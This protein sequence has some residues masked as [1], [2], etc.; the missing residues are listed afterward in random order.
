MASGSGK[1]PCAGEEI[2]Q[3]RLVACLRVAMLR[4]LMATPREQLTRLAGYVPFHALVALLEQPE[5]EFPPLERRDGAILR[6]ELSGISALAEALASR[7]RAGAEELARIESALLGGLLENALFP[8]DGYLLRFGGESLTA[9]FEGREA[10]LRAGWCA[11]TML[12]G[13]AAYGAVQ[14]AAGVRTIKA[15]AGIATGPFS[16]VYLG[17]GHDRVAC[18]PGGATVKRAVEGAQGA[19]WG[20]AVA[21]EATF[22]FAKGLQKGKLTQGGLL[23]VERAPEI[24]RTPVRHLDAQIAAAPAAALERLLPLVPEALAPT[25]EGGRAELQ[26]ELKRATV[27]LCRFG[28]ADW[29][30]AR[31]TADARAMGE[32][33]R[34]AVL[35]VRR[36]GGRVGPVDFALDGFRMLATFSSPGVRTDAE[37]AAAC[38]IELKGLGLGVAMEGGPTF[39]AEVGSGLKR[40]LAVAGDAADLAGRLL[41]LARLGDA[42][43]GPAVRGQLWGFGIEALPQVVFEEKGSPA[44]PGLLLAAPE[45]QPLRARPRTSEAKSLGGPI[46]RERELAVL[47]DR[48]QR[49]RSGGSALVLLHGESG[50]GKSV[51]LDALGADW[52]TSG[53]SAV[54]AR[55]TFADSERPWALAGRL[56]R[57]LLRLP[58]D[59]DPGKAPDAV[60]RL[61]RRLS[62][63]APYAAVLLGGRGPATPE[64]VAE[65]LRGIL[66]HRASEAPLLV[67][68][69][70]AHYADASSAAIW[71]ELA[72][73]LADRPIF[74]VAAHCREAL[75]DFEGINTERLE[76]D[77]LDPT[78]AVQV[79]AQLEPSLEPE[80]LQRAAEVGRGNPFRMQCAAQILRKKGKVADDADLLGAWTLGLEE[81]PQT[82]AELVAVFGGARASVE[83]LHEALREF[84][85]HA[86]GRDAIA[87]LEKRELLERRLGKLRFRARAVQEAIYERLNPERRSL[88]HGAIGRA[89]KLCEPESA[90]AIF[91]FHFARSDSRFE[92]VR[93]CIRAGEDA[94]LAGAWPE[95]A[96]FFGKA[97]RAAEASRAPELA[98]AL[99]R[100]A[101]ALVRQGRY[102]EVRALAE[103]AAEA[104]RKS[105]RT[106]ALSEA[107]SALAQAAL[108]QDDIE[109]AKVAATEA[110]EVVVWAKDAELA[111]ELFAMA[112]TVDAVAGD[113]RGA[114]KYARQAL[115]SAKRQGSPVLLARA[116]AALGA[117]AQVGGHLGGAAR[118][119]AEA[120][121][122]F[123]IAGDPGRAAR[124]GAQRALALAG[125]GQA[126]AA[127]SA[128]SELLG[129]A[130][131]PAAVRGVAHLAQ[132]LALIELK[133]PRE[134][135][136]A[137]AEARG[138][139]PRRLAARC[140]L[141]ELLSRALRNVGGAAEAIATLGGESSEPALQAHARY[142]AARAAFERGDS[143]TFADALSS[144]E[145][146]ARQH[147]RELLPS[148]AR[149]RAAAARP[150]GQP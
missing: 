43:V 38:A 2:D 129:Q 25:A 10:S 63:V 96:E 126:E 34:N 125:S 11:R 31:A 116:R 107:L 112:A 13:M 65:L 128:A 41:G 26:P 140:E 76:L 82:M 14:T 102:H 66:D 101:R 51:V 47:R 141:Y 146:L 145:F 15:R 62:P 54:T 60:S 121:R 90:P 98:D 89:M 149:L 103:R 12:E 117:A 139:V 111:A 122:L 68:V 88:L 108:A 92:A 81:D 109:R 46:G 85:R 28:A 80:Q 100:Q 134:A 87:A 79:L 124:S 36:A 27:V 35:A 74:W 127:L 148:I 83:V 131:T 99:A 57:Q 40:E 55:M 56:M 138:E 48:G 29:D 45:T 23:E 78:S 70:N 110:A 135:E 18:V 104:A 105:G 142:A 144:A 67:G 73:E 106:R 22:E 42:V 21:D 119:Q 150:T 6:L 136:S 133:R 17:V 32:T 24:A 72:K 16:L 19:P 69:D 9:F 39:V 4:G 30:G 71:R 118:E 5:R 114:V 52:S 33:F 130:E 75:P 95:A 3:L 77:A 64:A 53:G 137:L 84:D 58:S 115:R 132:G 44:A 50:V 91:A 147:A 120:Q 59:T 8:A 37:R 20:Q 93:T 61:D 49:V 97:A 123:S 113:V 94:L 7:G 143:A 86:N 1:P